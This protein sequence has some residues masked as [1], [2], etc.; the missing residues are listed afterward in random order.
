MS[1]NQKIVPHFVHKNRTL[2]AEARRSFN[3]IQE[4]VETEEEDRVV[5]NRGTTRAKSTS[6]VY[7]TNQQRQQSNRP[8]TSNFMYRPI[9]SYLSTQF[10]FK[11]V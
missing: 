3:T 2:T 5:V 8:N 11:I 1:A 6:L 4:S 10:Q 9:I 7:N